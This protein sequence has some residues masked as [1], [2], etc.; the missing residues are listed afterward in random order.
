MKKVLAL[1]ALAAM[2]T[3]A[4]AQAPVLVGTYSA[5]PNGN[6]GLTVGINWNDS[7]TASGFF[8]LTASSTT[9]Q[10]VGAFGGGL[11]VNTASEAAQFDVF[12]PAWVP[13]NDSYWLTGGPNPAVGFAGTPW[14]AQT[15][16]FGGVDVATGLASGP[17]YR[18]SYG[19]DTSIPVSG[20]TP[21]LYLVTSDPEGDVNISG[22]VAR[23]GADYAIN[24]NFT[25]AVQNP[26]LDAAGGNAGNVRIGTSGSLSASATNVGAGG[27][28][29]GSF[30]AAS[31]EFGGG[32]AAFGPLAPGASANQLYSYTPSGH[33][34]D[35]QVLTV[36][37]N[38]GN[39]DIT[40]S[41][42]GVGPEFA[43]DDADD[44]IDV[45]DVYGFPPAPGSASFTISNATGDGDLGGL[46][47]MTITGV[48]V[49]DNDGKVVFSTDLTAGTVI[50][51]GGSQLVTVTGTYGGL[52]QGASTGTL[53]IST[54]V[55]AALGGDGADFTF[56]LKGFAVP[57]PSTIAMAAF[58]ALGLVG[59]A[60][61]RRNG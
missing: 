31:G 24:Q 35:N 56:A 8:A 55:G 49:I 38:G 14:T 47:D 32:P 61:R 18:A 28:L 43:D 33:G 17:T 41:G 15:P 6:K 27:G 48:T 45:G 7:A 16:P 57:E 53:I 34:T 29:T 22:T 21:I 25:M 13:Q 36:T 58:G 50:A 5:T 54:D 59:M 51:A 12:D 19:T 11:P 10:Q 46:T 30:P 4:F 2:A 23:L 37:S 40:I 52:G 44:M 3:T 1:V 9:I 60:L 26:V 39:E 20:T 42:T